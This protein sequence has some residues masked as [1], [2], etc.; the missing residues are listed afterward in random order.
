MILKNNTTCPKNKREKLSFLSNLSWKNANQSN[1]K[2][3]FQGVKFIQEFVRHLPHKPGVYR[4]IGENGNILYIGKARN[5]KKRVSNYTREQGHNNRITRMIRATY[6]MEFIVTHTETEALLLEAN[7]IKR[8]HPHFNVLLRDDKSFPYIM[9]TNDHR[10]PALCKHRGARTQKAHY[11][12]PFASAGAVT[13]TIHVLQRA[14]LLRTCTDSIFENRTRPCLLYQIKR[15]SAPCT[16]EINDSDYKELVRE[17]KAFLSGKDQSVKNDMVQ[18]MHKAA[19][20][21]DFEQAAS[22]R[23][24]LSALSHIQSHQGINP[25]TIKEADV[26]AIAQKEGM[27]CIQVF[28]FRM[29]QNWGNRAYFPKADPS[30]SSTEI[31][32]SFLTQFYDDKP[33]PKNILL[34]EEIEEKTLLTE[35][36]SLK[37]NHKVSLS[38]P[39]KGERKTLV[40]HAYLNAHEALE[41]KL[42]ET[43]THTKLLQG[44]AET[45]Q[46]PF[47][48]RRIEVYDNSH[49]MGTNSVGAMIVAGQMGFVKNQYRKFN[50]RSTDITPGDDFGM[51]KEV[52]KRRFSRLIK[53]HDLPNKSHDRKDQEND[54]FPV[55]PDLI[56]IDGGEGQIN[57][58]HTILAEL[59]LNNLITVVGIAKGVDRHAGR[60]RFF[61]KGTLPFTLP[62]RDPILYFLQRL[63]DEAHRFAIGT[64]RIK[65][66]KE[67][68]KNPLDEIE[69][70][71]PSRKRALLH[72]FGSAKAVAGASLEDLKKVT[73]ISIAIAQ[74][75][76]NHF[77]EK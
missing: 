17:A 47:P 5:L 77:N 33:L 44:L 8:L 72:H 2:N 6:H 50:I 48:P 55:W 10:A 16:H 74:K 49:I 51:M 20:N 19:E 26:F 46:L 41:H 34:S 24:R 56:L 60:E 76:H 58:V 18:A 39:K 25:Q 13:Q 30:F 52:I 69:N 3:Q 28:F 14:F 31:L 38:L 4:M 54:L 11:F 27:T 64:H 62:P 1:E 21:L 32:A 71:G 40:N 75:I 57:S 70:I 67:T 22:Y 36:L 35:A 63:R 73:G 37:A 23:D 61:I 66:K 59:Q 53:E 68:F 43:A 45:F 7:L 42:A 9:I 12:G 65:R 29:G 15:C